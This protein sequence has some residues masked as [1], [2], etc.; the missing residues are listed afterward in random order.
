M[1]K[2]TSESMRIKKIPQIYHFNTQYIGLSQYCDSV[3]VK[4]H[5]NTINGGIFSKN[6][7][8]SEEYLLNFSM[9][10]KYVGNRMTAGEFY[11][12][13]GLLTLSEKSLGEDLENSI[14]LPK[15]KKIRVNLSDAIIN[16]RSVR[17]YK[18]DKMSLQNLSDLLFYTQGV[19]AIDKVKLDYYEEE[20]ELTLRNTSSGGGLYPVTLYFFARNIDKIEDGIYEYYPE[21]HSI[22]LVTKKETM[23]DVNNYADFAMIDVSNVNLIF[24]YV[25]NLLVNSRKYGNIGAAFGFLEAGQLSQ[26]IQLVSSSL[27]YGVCDIGGYVK[28]IVEKDLNID[29]LNKH[30][31]HMTIVG[32]EGE[33]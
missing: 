15:P 25:Y 4:M 24:F 9:N 1:D 6:R 31:I 2:T 7:F 10:N 29:G 12:A 21:S 8:S 19:S 13:G 32:S 17:F 23:S 27:G 11:Q 26:N 3:V 16:R 33:K 14:K 5:S 28:H 30:L 18:D 22:K 20:L